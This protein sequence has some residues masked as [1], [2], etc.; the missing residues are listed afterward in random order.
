MPDVPRLYGRMAQKDAA[1]CRKPCTDL[2]VGAQFRTPRCG[3]PGFDPAFTRP[4]NPDLGDL[5]VA[6]FPLAKALGQPPAQIAQRMGRPP[7]RRASSSSRACALESARG[8]G[9]FLNLR[10]ETASLLRA[11]AHA[12]RRKDPAS[13][14]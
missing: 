1:R 7:S 5:A 2:K 14:R 10:F 12:S 9:G 11:S 4:P 6:V 3:E 8:A 13:A